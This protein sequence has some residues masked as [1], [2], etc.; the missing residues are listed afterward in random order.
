MKGV[1]LN[2]FEDFAE[3]AFIARLAAN[4]DVTGP[5]EPR[6][7]NGRYDVAAL[8]DLV[9]RVSGTSG[10]EVSEVLRRFGIHLFSRFAALYP[11]FFIDGTSCLDFLAGL[12]T[13]I[14]GEVR[15][16]YPDAEFPSF[17][18]VRPGPGRLD[19]T[20]GSASGLAD[21]AEGLLLGCIA[22]FGEPIALERSDP[23]PRDGRTARF[24]LRRRAAR[25]A[26]RSSARGAGDRPPP[27]S[28]R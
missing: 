7:A 17:E 13:R 4:G 16:L 28:Q 2:E 12:D 27:P 6:D 22:Y 18:C 9:E 24:R 14:H 19:L 20:Y 23:P 15:K 5:H 3:A 21:F 8:R 11:A 26:G 10:V 25:S 1:I